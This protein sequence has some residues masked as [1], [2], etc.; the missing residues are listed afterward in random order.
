[1]GLLVDAVNL[2]QTLLSVHELLV[3][4]DHGFLIAQID[5]GNLIQAFGVLG[6]GAFLTGIESGAGDESGNIGAYRSESAG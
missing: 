4:G 3:N 2:S 6:N 1:M 5:I